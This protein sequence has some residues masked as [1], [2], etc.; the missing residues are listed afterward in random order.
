MAEADVLV[1]IDA[2]SNAASV[3]LPSKLVD[4]MMFKKP[5]LGITPINGAS[6]DLL[7]RLDCHVI[8]P[9][10]VQGI[11]K[12]VSDLIRMWQWKKLNISTAFESVAQEYDICQTTDTLD[13]VLK[14]L[15]ST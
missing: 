1:V 15:V 4:Y 2:P 10:D 3:F 12:A 5:I 7:R 6:A 13:K 9:D 14:K 8:A 11:A